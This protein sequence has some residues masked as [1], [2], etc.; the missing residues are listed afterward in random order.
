[1]SEETQKDVLADLQAKSDGPPAGTVLVPPVTCQ[2]CGADP[3]N[4][5]NH[6]FGVCPICHKTDGYLN[7]GNDHWFLCHT[8][9]TKWAVG[10]NLFSSCMDETPEQQRAEQE[11]IGFA[12]YTQVRAYYR[13]DTPWQDDGERGMSLEEFL[14]SLKSDVESVE[15]GAHD[16][17]YVDYCPECAVFYA[18]CGEPNSAT[19]N[20]CGAP[21]K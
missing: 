3:C 1:M 9:K 21:R 14:R 12:S 10:A 18:S 20:A 16:I 15:R 13:V 19:C 6:H 4:A 17:P 11:K 2:V 5:A 8:H 7:V